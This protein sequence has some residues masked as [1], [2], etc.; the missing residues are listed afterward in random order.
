MPK[1]Q[2][3]PTEI[4]EEVQKLIDEFNRVDLKDSTSLLDAFFPKKIKRG[5]SARFKGKYL[6]LDRTDRYEPLPICRLTW[7]GNMDNWDFAI[8]KYSS[9]KYDS[10][11]WFFPGEEE[12]DG[13][14]TGAMK[15]GMIA[16]EIQ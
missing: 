14:I 6:Y 7:N 2:A 15:A 12:V 4:Q 10:E 9:E 8:Y 5:Y 11:E 1:K 13:A 3:I 16:Y